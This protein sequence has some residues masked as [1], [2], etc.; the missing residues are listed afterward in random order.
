MGWCLHTELEQYI[1]LSLCLV[2]L[3]QNLLNPKPT[4]FS[5]AGS[6]QAMLLSVPPPSVS[7]IGVFRTTPSFYAGVG[8]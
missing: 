8:P 4:F 6:Q 2:A 1:L 5:E 7:I 3:R